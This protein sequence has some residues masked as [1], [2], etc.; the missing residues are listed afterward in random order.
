MSEDFSVSGALPLMRPGAT[1]WNGI[2]G[3]VHI[4]LLGIWPLIGAY[5]IGTNSGHSADWLSGL[6]GI[7]DG[8]GLVSGITGLILTA[9]PIWGGLWVLNGVAPAVVNTVFI[10]IFPTLYLLLVGHFVLDGIGSFRGWWTLY[11][12]DT[13]SLLNL[14][15][16]PVQVTGRAQVVE[17]TVKAPYTETETL[18][19]ESEHEHYTVP[20]HERDRDSPGHHDEG[21]EVHTKEWVTEESVED[22]VPFELR[23]DG[24]AALVD[25]TDARLSLDRSYREGDDET[26]DT[27]RRVDPGETVYV[28]GTAVPAADLDRETH[29]YDYVITEPQSDLSPPIRRLRHIP[30][31]LSTDGEGTARGDLFRRGIQLAVLSLILTAPV[32][33]GVFGPLLVRVL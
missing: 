19:Y 30:F 10:L 18:V 26:R 15:P 7:E 13:D 16:G 31:T 6:P 33:V 27:E 20:D 8:G 32:L 2:F 17:A 22:D 5:L 25:P 3:I 29:G 11:R 14:S 12:S 1:V 21:I 23:G 28:S 4:C 9:V 24:G